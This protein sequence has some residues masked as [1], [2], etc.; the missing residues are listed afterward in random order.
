MT[1]SLRVKA[2]SKEVKNAILQ[3]WVTLQVRFND[4]SHQSQS[5]PVLKEEIVLLVPYHTIYYRI[6]PSALRLHTG[7][8]GLMPLEFDCIICC[9]MMS[10]GHEAAYGPCARIRCLLITCWSSYICTNKHYVYKDCWI[11]EMAPDCP[12]VDCIKLVGPHFPLY[13]LCASCHHYFSTSHHLVH[14][15]LCHY[16]VVLPPRLLSRS[17]PSTLSP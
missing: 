2:G 11:V 15:L 10:L 1:K 8:E 17:L 12:S 6:A 4:S 13:F 5:R 16:P 3:L 14:L 7:H 9:A